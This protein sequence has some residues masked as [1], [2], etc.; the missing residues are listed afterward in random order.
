METI[1]DNCIGSGSTAIAAIN[2]H[3]QW[4]GFELESTYYK[5]AKDRINQH[6]IN[7]NM[8]DTYSEMHE[9]NNK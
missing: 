7:S 9:Y 3:R 2:T 8:Q 6:I 1:L 4:I 5:V